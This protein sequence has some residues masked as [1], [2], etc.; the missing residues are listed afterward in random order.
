KSRVR[1][2]CRVFR[3]HLRLIVGTSLGAILLSGGYLVVVTPLYT[4]SSS[5]LVE[6][7]GST[8]F[9]S[10]TRIDSGLSSQGEIPEAFKTLCNLLK[11]QSLA[12]EV[13]TH[14][15]LSWQNLSEVPRPGS[16]RTICK[17]LFGWLIGS[18]AD[19]TRDGR[20]AI[21]SPA[22]AGREVISEYLR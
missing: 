11:S 15:G 10:G 1:N 14:L 13:V 3:K 2:L 12:A 19:S 5:V 6:P 7:F 16:I 4:A 18:P 8:D 20:G 21:G 9:G 22:F 17:S